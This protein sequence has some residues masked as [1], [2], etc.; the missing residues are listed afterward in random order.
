MHALAIYNQVA[1]LLHLWPGDEARISIADYQ[2]QY[3]A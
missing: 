2:H 1:S 3:L